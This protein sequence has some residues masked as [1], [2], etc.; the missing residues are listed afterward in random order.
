MMHTF[1]W[2]RAMEACL[3]GAVP[4]MAQSFV[5]GLVYQR[6]SNGI[7]PVSHA[8]IEARSAATGSILAEVTADDYGAYVLQDLPAGEVL[9][10]VG[11]RATT[12]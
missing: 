12:L 8:R 10:K 9:L 5:S 3:L 4:L 7:V 11:I 6:R 1:L 2:V